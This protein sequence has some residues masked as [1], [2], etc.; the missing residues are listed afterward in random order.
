MWDEEK[1][2]LQQR[3]EQFLAEQLKVKEM[4]HISLRFVTVIEVKV[5]EKVPQ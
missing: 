5:E 1:A 2:Q 4:V 3:K